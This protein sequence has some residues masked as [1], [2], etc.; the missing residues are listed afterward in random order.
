MDIRKS[1]F[2]I[3]AGDIVNMVM[4]PDGTIHLAPAK[5]KRAPA[6]QSTPSTPPP[7]SQGNELPVINSLGEFTNHQHL[8][9][10]LTAE[11]YNSIEVYLADK[12]GEFYKLEHIVYDSKKNRLYLVRAWHG[13]DNLPVKFDPELKETVQLL[14]ELAAK[15]PTA[16]KDTHDSAKEW[17]EE[18]EAP[19]N[20][21]TSDADW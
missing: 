1:E 9:A 3:N 17:D 14:D 18:D 15:S 11:D 21:D 16:S 19:S 6:T 13:E 12:D 10:A 2:I 7:S 4:D 5:P 20:A 8:N